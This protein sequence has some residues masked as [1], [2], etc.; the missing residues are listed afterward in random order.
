VRG[1]AAVFGSFCHLFGVRRLCR[2]TASSCA[3]TDVF[4]L[5]LRALL[6]YSATPDSLGISPHKDAG[7][8][9]LLVQDDVA[10]LQVGTASAFFC[11]LPPVLCAVSL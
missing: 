4:N 2:S 11:L 8:L 5:I 7:F 6:Y 1:T 10:G 3:W 9:T